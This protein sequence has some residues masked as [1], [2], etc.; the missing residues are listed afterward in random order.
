MILEKHLRGDAGRVRIAMDFEMVPQCRPAGMFHQQHGAGAGKELHAADAVAP[1]QKIRAA[2]AVLIRTN[3]LAWAVAEA[4][5]EEIDQ[6]NI[7]QASLLAMQR[8]VAALKIAPSQ[9]LID[10]NRCPKLA[11]SA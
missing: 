10:G 3:A 5:V 7:L 8:A 9:A 1:G 6:I 11:C 4:S 2:L